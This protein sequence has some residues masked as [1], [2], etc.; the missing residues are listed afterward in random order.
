MSHD[1]NLDGTSVGGG[2]DHGD[3]PLPSPG[4]R[5][6]TQNIV[7]RQA[8]PETGARVVDEGTACEVDHETM[9]RDDAERLGLNCYLAKDDRTRLLGVLWGVADSAMDNYRDA[10]QNVRLDK[11]LQ[12]D[13]SKWGFWA[14]FLF[15]TV[16]GPLIGSAVNG[17][18]AVRA[19]AVAA[20]SVN[21]H[22]R[23]YGIAAKDVGAFSKAL[24]NVKD[25]DIAAVLQNASRGART[26]LKSRADGAG[27]DGAS[28]AVLKMLQSRIK[29]LADNIRIEAPVLLD[30]AALAAM[31]QA[32]R[33]PVAHSVEAYE[34]AINDML[35]RFDDQ[36]LDRIGDTIKG[37]GKV[38][39][40][41]LEACGHRRTA[42]LADHGT[43]LTGHGLGMDMKGRE[44]V[45]DD[46]TDYLI[47]M[48]DDDMAPLTKELYAGTHETVDVTGEL[49]FRVTGTALAAQFEAWRALAKS[50]PIPTI[51]TI[52]QPTVETIPPEEQATHATESYSDWLSGLF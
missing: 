37:G 36:Q 42:V 28:D 13:P 45:Y 48:V 10:I 6:L 11:K 19:A 21:S 4:K 30:D 12:K 9:N 3:R 15:Y 31:M 25:E 49:P 51:E 44:A 50:K 27:G 32:Y 7:R 23:Q 40:V 35:T 2:S 16:T 43:G 47:S 46:G 18:K 34:A 20:K 39:P 14:E 1:Y 38:R 52:P 8:A 29:E 26:E 41:V 17:L 22:W 33:D 5:T 24:T